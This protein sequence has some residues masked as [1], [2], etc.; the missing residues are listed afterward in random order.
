MGMLMRVHHLA[1]GGPMNRLLETVQCQIQEE[2]ALHPLARWCSHP[3]CFRR[4]SG[5]HYPVEPAHIGD[6]ARREG[7]STGDEHMTS[8]VAR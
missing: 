8:D 5:S 3:N 4:D 1:G 7:Q 6:A 2:A